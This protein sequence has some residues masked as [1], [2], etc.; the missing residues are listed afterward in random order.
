MGMKQRLCLLFPPDL[1]K[2]NIRQLFLTRQS[3]QAY[4]VRCPFYAQLAPIKS[5]SIRGGA[6][7]CRFG[8][9]RDSKRHITDTLGRIRSM[10]EDNKCRAHW[11]NVREKGL[12]IGRCRSV[13]KIG[14]EERRPVGH[15]NYSVGERENGTTNP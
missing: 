13:W 11:G 7:E 8:V 14:H 12:Q 4:F 2:V 9:L 15:R 6:V 1:A 10:F 3:T 5:D